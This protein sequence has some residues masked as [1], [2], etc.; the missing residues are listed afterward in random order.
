LA[1]GTSLTNSRVITILIRRILGS[2]YW[3]W[4]PLAFEINS[5][6]VIIVICFLFPKFFLIPKGTVGLINLG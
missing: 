5:L 6:F 1:F 2:L 4:L 3:Y